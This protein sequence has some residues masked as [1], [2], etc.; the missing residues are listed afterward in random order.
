MR[1]S[2]IRDDFLA[3]GAAPKPP[4]LLRQLIAEGKGGKDG[5]LI[6]SDT[7]HF[8]ADTELDKARRIVLGEA[9]QSLP[10]VYVSSRDSGELPLDPERLAADL[11]GMAHVI[12]EPD[13]AFSFR[14][15]DATRGQ[16]AY[17]G[18]VG[19]GFPGKPTAIRGFP[20]REPQAQHRSLVALVRETSIGRLA[21]LGAEWEDLQHLASAAARARMADAPPPE[22]SRSDDAEWRQLYEGEIADQAETIKKLRQE[23]GRLQARLEAG[24]TASSLAQRLSELKE[25]VGE[26]YEGELLDRL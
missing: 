13:R 16:N 24:M 7:P 14:L 8:I 22:E 4:V 20:S 12:V 10:V 9:S 2:C 17:A 15:R 11:A 1:V 5:E 3:E 21:R 19:L 18:A 25:A 6:V 26:I 23:N